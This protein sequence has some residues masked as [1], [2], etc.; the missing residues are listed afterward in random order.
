MSARW[1]DILHVIERVEA[2]PSVTPEDRMR[3]HIVLELEGFCAGIRDGDEYGQG[4][5]EAVERMRSVLDDE[6]ED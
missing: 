4:Y 6:E 3:R 2:M 1:E 5:K